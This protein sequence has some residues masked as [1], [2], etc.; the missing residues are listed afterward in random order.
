MRPRRALATTL[1]AATVGACGGP[2]AGH[3]H[4][5]AKIKDC[6]LTV[7]TLFGPAPGNTD[8]DLRPIDAQEDVIDLSKVDTASIV[9][10]D[11][12]PNGSDGCSTANSDTLPCDAADVR[13]SMHNS[14]GTIEEYALDEK[15]L[16]RTA[17]PLP[18]NHYELVV[19]YRA[20]APRFAEALKTISGMCGA[21]PDAF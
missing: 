5:G 19:V 8:S 21:R 15:T 9:S 11:T 3:Y 14:E 20:Y 1:L 10:E 4:T 17:G 6:V 16:A 13:F 7:Q 12:P 2:E 18:K